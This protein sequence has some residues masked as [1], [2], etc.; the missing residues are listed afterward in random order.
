ME[1]TIITHKL[2]HV[3]RTQDPNKIV[4]TETKPNTSNCNSLVIKESPEDHTLFDRCNAPIDPLRR[5]VHPE[6][7][8]RDGARDGTVAV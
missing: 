5:N 8:D 1:L 3:L 6:K 4:V 2:Q 7:P